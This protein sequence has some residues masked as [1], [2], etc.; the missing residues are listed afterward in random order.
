ME[1][2]ITERSLAELVERETELQEVEYDT[3]E[4][5]KT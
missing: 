4:R 2:E 1:K 3:E 5:R